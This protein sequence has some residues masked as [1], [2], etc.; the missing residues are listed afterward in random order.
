MIRI[1][2]KKCV[3]LKKVTCCQND[4]KIIITKIV[5]HMGC[6]IKPLHSLVVGLHIFWNNIGVTQ[7]Y[8]FLAGI[9][10]I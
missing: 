1:V 3:A 9:F 5:I 10:P 4:S 2:D 7:D 8:I 6:I